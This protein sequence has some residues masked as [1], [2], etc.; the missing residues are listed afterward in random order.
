MSDR[1]TDD[2]VVLL[3]ALL[4]VLDR[5]AFAARYLHPGQ[6]PAILDACGDVD[7]ELAAE[8]P[9]L[10]A[11]PDDLAHV[12]GPLGTAADE[13]LAGFAALR[14]GGEDLTA[15]FKAFRH[16]PRAEEALYPLTRG[17][18]PVSRFFLDGTH[19]DDM[20]LAVRLAEAPPRPNTG[21]LHSDETPGGR[22]GF[23]MFVPETYDPAQP[24]PLVMAL[25][26]GSGNGRAF[27]W[28]WLRAA[29]T[30]G[31]ILVAP[32]AIGDTWALTGDDVDT[33]N[34]GRIVDFVRGRWRI[35]PQH[36]LL[37]G[38]SD[39]G[40]FT[41]VSGM[42]PASPFTHL[43]PVSAAFHPM[44]ASFADPAR[45]AGL[46]IHIVHGAMDWMFPVSMARDA[47]AA[48]EGAGAAVIYREVDDLSHTYARELSGVLLDWMTAG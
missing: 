45:L 23:S 46:P 5:L 30:R 36:M 14:S 42:D 37:T 28:S 1:A 48:L 38:M 20:A 2:I 31:A 47:Q 44:L 4:R 33:P 22:G 29:R 15:A 3:P 16:L 19:R 39:G 6:L 24:A 12:R 17:L 41:Y 25:H 13:A 7:A 8:R 9:R 18:P 32:T 10:D 11:W 21:V 35:D 26:G 43:A 27:L 40:T 34:L